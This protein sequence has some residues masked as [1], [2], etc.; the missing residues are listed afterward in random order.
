[1]YNLTLSFIYI[2]NMCEGK[3]KMAKY[4]NLFF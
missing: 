1:M 3:I 2:V 4:A